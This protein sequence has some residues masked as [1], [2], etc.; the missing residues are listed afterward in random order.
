MIITIK[1]DIGAPKK[2]QEENVERERRKKSNEEERSAR[3]QCWLDEGPDQAPWNILID[4]RLD[5]VTTI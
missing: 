3:L 4:A 5:S 2:P 1:L